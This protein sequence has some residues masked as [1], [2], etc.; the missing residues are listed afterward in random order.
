MSIRIVALVGSARTG[1][2][3]RQLAETAIKLTPERDQGRRPG[4]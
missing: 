4:R 1:S 3:N 2:H